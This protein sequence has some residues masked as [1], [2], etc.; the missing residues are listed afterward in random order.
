MQYCGRAAKF[1]FDDLMR[2]PYNNDNPFDGGAH[3]DQRAN[4]ASSPED[5]LR[6]SRRNGRQTIR[7]A[8]QLVR[9][10]YAIS[11]LVRGPMRSTRTHRF[12]H[13]RICA[14]DQ[15]RDAFPIRTMTAYLI[16]G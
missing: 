9:M 11:R 7:S 16:R 2:G 4:E 3:V 14:A 12:L 5:C 1:L 10:L 15:L 6:R 8:G 13:E